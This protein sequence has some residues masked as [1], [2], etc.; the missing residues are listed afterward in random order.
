[1]TAAG[2]VATV[3]APGGGGAAVAATGQMAE[4]FEAEQADASG[5]GLGEL[6]PPRI[7]HVVRGH[8]AGHWR[9]ADLALPMNTCTV[10]ASTDVTIL[11]DTG[12]QKRPE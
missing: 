11:T 6:H 8:R 4:G 3:T 2:T 9:L 7:P 10:P 5:T 12:Q 1:M